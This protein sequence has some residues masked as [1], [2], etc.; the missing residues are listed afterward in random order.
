VSPRAV[1][2]SG[3]VLGIALAACL[4]SGCDRFTPPLRSPASG[5][6]PWRELDSDHFALYTDVD[7]ED[8]RRELREFEGLRHALEE[9]SFHGDGVGEPRVAL[10][11]F[12]R[13]ADYDA[14]GPKNAVGAANAQLPIDLERQPVLLFTG[15]MTNAMRRT[16]VHEEVHELMHRTYGNTPPWLN[17]GLASYFSSLRVEEGH[18]VLGDNVPELLALPLRMLPGPSE[19][20]NPDAQSVYH[21]REDARQVERMGYYESA[22]L[23][24]HLLRNGPQAYRSRFDV[25]ADA[26]NRGLP[27]QQAWAEA[28]KGL[29]SAQLEHDFRAHVLAPSWK[30]IGGPIAPAPAV[31]ISERALRPAEVHLLWARLASVKDRA[32]TARQIEAAAALEPGSGAVSYARGSAAMLAGDRK[33]AEVA[34]RRALETAPVDPRYLFAVAR[35]T[36]DC[37]SSARPPTDTA[38]CEALVAGARTSEEQALAALYLAR[39]GQANDALQRAYRA[40]HADGRCAGCAV[41]L[42]ELLVGVGRPH[43]AIDVLEQALSASPETRVDRAVSQMLANLRRAV[44][45]DEAQPQSTQ[46]ERSSE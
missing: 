13:G 4:S 24:V 19:T 38:L 37:G 28:T 10:V 18:V 45:S 14:L 26:L 30:L 15:D 42:A 5:G 8:A 36:G 34:F 2:A 31:S 40:L 17:E 6:A 1:T 25:L 16:F 43:D 41:V 27:A 12:R 32:L 11:V 9:S 33:G 22:W 3:T 44:R 7:P 39:L 35:A 29:T 21:E 20:V 46:P 23:L